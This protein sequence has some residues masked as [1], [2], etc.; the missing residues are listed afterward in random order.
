MMRSLF[1]CF[2]C[3]SSLVAVPA[4]S[5]A[6]G[7]DEEVIRKN[8]VEMWKQVA[9][10]KLD[11]SL[12]SPN[13]VTQATSAGGFWRTLSRAENVAQINDDDSTLDFRPAYIE[14]RLLGSKKDVAHVSYY[15]SGTIFLNGAPPITNYRTRVSQVWEKLDGK[16]VVAAAH[17]SPL[18]G[19][20]GVQPD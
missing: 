2:V 7:H 9:A 3:L 4:I 6:D 15:L 19:G 1:V 18:F 20:S 13:G 5:L 8:V 11:G 10:K 14:V 12:T 16:W 17:Y